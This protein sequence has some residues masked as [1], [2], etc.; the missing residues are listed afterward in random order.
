MQAYSAHTDSILYPRCSHTLAILTS[1]ARSR[2][3]GA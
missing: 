3:E 1:K 2:L